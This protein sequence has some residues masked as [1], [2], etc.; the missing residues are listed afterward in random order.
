MDTLNHTNSLGVARGISVPNTDVVCMV[1]IAPC[2]RKEVFSESLIG[3]H[4][5]ILSSFSSKV[6]ISGTESFQGRK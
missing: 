5:G 3:Y 1:L 2:R 4:L 6:K